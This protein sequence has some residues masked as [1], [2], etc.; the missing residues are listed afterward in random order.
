MKKLIALLAT[1]AL[2]ACLAPGMALAAEGGNLQAGSP[3]ISAQADKDLGKCSIKF[4][5]KQHITKSTSEWQFYYV[6]GKNIAAKPTFDLYYNGKKVSK[7]KYTVS[8]RLTWWSGDKE[9]SKAAKKLIPSASPEATSNNMN[10]EYRIIVKAKKG[11]GFSGVYDQASITVADWNNIGHFNDLQLTKAKSAWHYAINGM[12][13]NYYV[14]PQ[15]KVKATLNSLKVRG[16]YSE[17]GKHNGKVIDKKNYKVTYYAAKKNVI[18]KNMP[19]EKAKT[20]KALKSAPTKAGSYVML[21]KGKK[22]FYGTQAILF[23]VQDKMTNV[24]VASIGSQK[25][26]GS[27]VTPSL[28]VTYKGKVLKKNVDYKVTFKNNVEA[29]KA[30][31]IITGCNKVKTFE[32]NPSTGPAIVE[33]NK[34]RFFSGSKSVTFEIVK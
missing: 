14:I 33:K 32:F 24:K 20:G 34:D 27:P 25:Y 3:D 18:A 23:D 2:V 12:N 9:K 28:K 13:R 21:I 11:S 29:G 6:N 30:T 26:T 4:T 22:P 10:S 8:Y 31:A 7:K 1:I 17:E 5:D 15:A 16:N 19:L